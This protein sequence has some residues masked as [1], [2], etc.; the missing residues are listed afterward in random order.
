MGVDG[1]EN[2]KNIKK[3]NENNGRRGGGGGGSFWYIFKHADRVDILLMALGFFGAVGDGISSPIMYVITGRIMNSLGGAASSGGG[4]L[5]HHVNQNALNF[6]YLACW[7]WVAC[8]LEGYCWTRTGERQASRLRLVYMKAVLRQEVGYFDLHVSS[9]ADVIHSVSLDTMLIQDVI[10]E[11]IPAMLTHMALFIS[12]YVVGFMLMWRLALVGVPFIVFLV[13]PGLIY[14]R[15]LSGIGRKMR[16]EY[17]KA[18]RVVEQAISSV[19]TVYSFVGEEVTV[20]NYSS[21]L[22]RT[23]KLGLRQG[24]AKGLA[25]GSNGIV[26]AIWAFMAYFGSRLVMYHGAR[27]GTVFA[28]GSAIARGG[29]ALGPVF[30]D[31]KHFSEASLS[32]ER[33]MEVIKRAPEIDSESPEGQTLESISGE[34]EFRNVEFAYPTRPESIILKDFNLR[35]LAGK[36]VALV[37]ESGSGKSTVVGLIQRFYDPTRGEISL[38][39]VRI[40]RLQLKWLRSQMGLVSQEGALFG[41]TIKE[42]IMFGRENASRDEVIDAA[43]AANAHDFISQLP[44]GYDTQVG[45][46][47]VQMSGGERQRIAIARAIIKAPKILLLD[48]ATSALDSE[49]ERA[50]QQALDHASTGRTT[51][52]VAHRLSTIKNA[53][54]IA[55]IQ[56]GHVKEVGSHD[57]PIKGGS[58]GIY[59]SLARLHH[60]ENPPGPT[61]EELSRLDVPLTTSQDSYS[62]SYSAGVEPHHSVCPVENTTHG[63]P[64]SFRRLLTMNAPEWRQAALGS[65]GAMLFGGVQPMFALALG[66]MVSAYFLHN[67]GEIKEKIRMYALCFLGLAIFSLLVNILQHYNFAS[68]GEYLTKRIRKRMLS[69]MLTFEIAWFDKDENGTGAVCSR[70]SKDA[71]VVRSLVGDRMGLLIQATSAVLI[72]WTMGLVIAWKLGLV[73]IA[74]QPLII[75]CYYSK[76]VMLKTMSKKAKKAQEETGKLAG[77]ALANLRTITAFSSQTRILEMLEKAQ[78]IP[79]AENVRQSWFAGAGLATACGLTTCTRALG[80][81]Y[82]GKL[83]AEGS[84]TARS[85]FQTFQI[86]LT[87]G[88]VIADAGTMTNDLA[89]GSDTVS[90]VFS[91]LDRRSLIEPDE[92]EKLKPDHVRGHVEIKKVDFAYP[93]RPNTAIFER[94]SVVFEAG[95]STALVGPSGSGKSTVIGLV[96][97][98]YDPINGAVLID[99]RDVRSYHLR[100]L[101][102]HIALVNQE[103]A[104]FAGTVRENIAYGAASFAA[105]EAEIAEAAKLANAHEFI[106]ALRDGYDTWCGERGVQLSGGQKQRIAIARA[107]L[108][109]PAI[110]LLDEATSALDNQSE[111]TVQAA[112]ER[113]MVG[114]TSV[115]V[116]HRLSTVYDC[117]TIVVLD[118]GKVVEQGNHSTLLAKGPSGT[119]Y[120]LVHIQRTSYPI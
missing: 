115:V 72:A 71:N 5:S 4:S 102:E 23:L 47:G 106:T 100:A 108:K 65:T 50:V 86:L 48:E 11:K 79:R 119:Y 103:P 19:R 16:E 96:E 58:G 33:I 99:G 60:P 73:M 20:R 17:G 59:S 98:F 54:L 15:A 93:A 25:V 68:M 78:E 77:E 70:L 85:V 7:Q 42:N 51:V 74:V 30:S 91:V 83:V 92:D 57:R 3:T 61:N 55:V 21:A 43:K 49:S 14:G 32:L 88:R 114:R 64:P 28:V 69:K 110:L 44:Q 82:G 41:T 113:V 22:E 116:A 13:I 84:V 53:D 80:Y 8:F 120:S 18:G 118:K 56:N 6:C 29:K 66:S 90:S 89:K 24:L 27:G 97:R 1:K 104:L 95:K 46:R 52:I 35:V 34:L 12:S 40:D 109:K 112:L 36:T 37:G 81:W 2:N 107:L 63:K 10:S 26:F 31:M 94:F 9:S 87:T 111:K 76:R 67:H 75:A 39:G 62:H 38:D 101:R 117:D 105:S 45:E